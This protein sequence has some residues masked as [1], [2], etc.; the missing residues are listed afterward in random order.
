[1]PP[2]DPFSLALQELGNVIRTTF[3]LRW[4]WD[5]P[6]RRSVHKGTT[7]VERSH[8]FSKYLNFGGEGGL[9]TNNPADQGK[10]I[11]YNELVANALALQ[12]VADQTRA[13]HEL[14]QRGIE[15]AAEDLSHSVP[16][17]PVA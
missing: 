1:M 15:I 2:R 16:I 3:L 12:T 7:K 10:A 8:Q 6:M 14:R 17:Q 11:V 9:R 13:L 4:T 5:K